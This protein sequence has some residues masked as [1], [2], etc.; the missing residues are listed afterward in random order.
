MSLEEPPEDGIKHGSERIGRAEQ[1]DR[2]N[3]KDDDDNDPFGGDGCDSVAGG[4]AFSV[5]AVGDDRTVIGVASDTGVVVSRGGLG[6]VQG[7][8]Q[9]ADIRQRQQRADEDHSGDAPRALLDRAE[10]DEPLA[11]GVPTSAR[12]AI[13]IMPDVIGARLARPA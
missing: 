10:G 12:P 4:C 9:A 5:A 3:G 6:E 7:F 8:E 2:R 11:E 1:R 13:A